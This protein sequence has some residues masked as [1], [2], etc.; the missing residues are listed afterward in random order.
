MFFAPKRRRES[1]TPASA[2]LQLVQLIGSPVAG[3]PISSKG[4]QI[5]IETHM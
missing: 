3:L 2:L 4:D 5:V 1:K